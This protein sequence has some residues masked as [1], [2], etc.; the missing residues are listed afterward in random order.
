MKFKIGQKIQQRQLQKQTIEIE[1]I[2][3]EDEL[4]DTQC[5]EQEKENEMDAF[6]REEQNQRSY[7]ERR[8][9][10]IAEEKSR[11]ARALFYIDG[12]A[13]PESWPELLDRI[14]KGQFVYDQKSADLHGPSYSPFAYVEWRDPTRTA[15]RDGFEAFRKKLSVATEDAKDKIRVL[16]PDQGLEALEAL[17]AFPVQ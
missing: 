14:A 2:P 5:P 6:V 16:M 8:M 7:L 9:W 1:P 12:D 10:S 15:D 13:V 17:K 4:L 3:Y 11:A